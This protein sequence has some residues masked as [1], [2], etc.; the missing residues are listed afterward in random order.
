MYYICYKTINNI[1][2][3]YYIGAH[4]TANVNDDYLGSG[5]L[6]KDAL[7]KYGRENFSKQI[8][9]IFN[10]K[11]DMWEKERELVNEEMV[12]KIDNYNLKPGGLGSISGNTHFMW[13][14]THTPE[15]RQKISQARKNKPTWNKGK[16]SWNAGKKMSKEWSERLK[17]RKI[18]NEWKEKI[19]IA[20]LGTKASEETKQKMI[21]SKLG[22]K[23]GPY[24][25]YKRKNINHH[26]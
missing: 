4:S 6:L 12:H 7:K 15:A 14:K 8:L 1:N 16:S 2:G 25:S 24:K 13:G 17:T 26:A 3:K 20:K 19:R 5:K 9:F 21:L 10:N 11:H 23:R 22:K 18:S